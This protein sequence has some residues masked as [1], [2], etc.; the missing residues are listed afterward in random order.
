[1]LHSS[2]QRLA[3][4]Q[5]EIIKIMMLFDGYP[6]YKSHP[7]YEQFE[8]FIQDVQRRGCSITRLYHIFCTGKVPSELDGLIREHA[9]H[10]RPVGEIV[11]SVLEQRRLLSPE[12]ETA[13]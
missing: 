3:D 6:E 12:D 9:E 10:W 2:I 1:M 8:F 4:E 11:E 5:G 7:T 13:S